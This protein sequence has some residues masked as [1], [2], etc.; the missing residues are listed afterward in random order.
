MHEEKNFVRSN[1]D[2][3]RTAESIGPVA[4]TT[5]YVGVILWAVMKPAEPDEVDAAVKEIAFR[6]PHR[7]VVSTEAELPPKLSSW[8]TPWNNDLPRRLD[9]RRP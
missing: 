7:L 8:L 2:Q 6:F 5:D 3:P 9:A 4:Y 1:P